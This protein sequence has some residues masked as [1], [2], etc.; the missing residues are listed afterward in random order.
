MPK[1]TLRSGERL[2][3]GE[4]L[5]SKN[6]YH[7]L[8]MQKDGN[9]VLYSLGVSVWA[10]DTNGKRGAWLAMQRDGNL[11]VYSPGGKPLWATGTDGN[12]KSELVVQDD[13]NAVVYCTELKRN[14]TWSTKTNTDPVLWQKR[15]FH[16]PP[17][18]MAAAANDE[19]LGPMIGLG[20]ECTVPSHGAVVC[21]GVLILILILLE[22]QSDE[23]F[24]PNN[25]IRVIGGKIS[26]RSKKASRDFYHWSKNKE[27]SVSKTLKKWFGS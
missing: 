10:S 17:Q 11:V 21:V 4:K 5:K 22:F 7:V 26:D 2:Q 24:G 20:V 9:L 25:D 13:R 27:D 1:S 19:Q 18:L 23:P 16:A 3:P 15:K 6:G 12:G 8:A 14:S